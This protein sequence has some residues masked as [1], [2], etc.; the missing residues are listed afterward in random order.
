LA[1]GG[2]TEEAAEEL[3]PG[4]TV[5]PQR[6]KPDSKQSSYRSAE[7]L[8]HPKP[9]AKWSFSAACEVVPF[10]KTRGSKFF[11]TAK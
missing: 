4:Q 3:I 6:L 5:L 7:A 1:S 11:G 10:P 2:T 8:R 9:S